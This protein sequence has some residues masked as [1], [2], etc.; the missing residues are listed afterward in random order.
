MGPC[1]AFPDVGSELDHGGFAMQGSHGMAGAA[2][3]HDF[4][5]AA[6]A[7][8]ALRGHSEFE[9]DVVET[10]AGTRVAGDFAVGDAAADADDHGSRFGW[11]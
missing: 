11:R 9:L 5:G 3:I 6:F 7:L 2:L 4:A 1:C 8:P 10:H